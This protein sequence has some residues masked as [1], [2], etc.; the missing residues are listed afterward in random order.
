MGRRLTQMF[1]HCNN[2]QVRYTFKIY[3]ITNYTRSVKCNCIWVGEELTQFPLYLNFLSMSEN[4]KLQ[5][6]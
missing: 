1:Q 4:T 5:G 2:T 3:S 6:K